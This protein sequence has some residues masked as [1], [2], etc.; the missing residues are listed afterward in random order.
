M[1]TRKKTFYFFN[2]ELFS[3]T[4]NFYDVTQGNEVIEIYVQEV[5]GCEKGKR[6][7]LPI[8]QAGQSFSSLQ[9]NLL[10]EKDKCSKVVSDIL[11]S[12]RIIRGLEER[13]IY[14]SNFVLPAPYY[15]D[16]SIHRLPIYRVWYY[17]EYLNMMLAN[18][19]LYF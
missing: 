3:P 18:A 11:V 7:T 4:G 19:F 10:Y 1:P 12:I 2:W 14:M 6:Y 17:D 9:V 5:D 15:T 8:V 16:G 13:V